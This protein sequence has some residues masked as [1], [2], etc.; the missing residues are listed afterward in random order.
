MHAFA[1]DVASRCRR[2]KIGK[3]KPKERFDLFRAGRGDDLL[4]VN[5]AYDDEARTMATRKKTHLEP[6]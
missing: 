5:I 2:S 1:K 4:A 3:E 6:W